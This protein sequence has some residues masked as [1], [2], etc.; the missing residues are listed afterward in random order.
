MDD[1]GPPRAGRVPDEARPGRR[2]RAGLPR[3]SE[4]PAEQRL[5]PLRPL[6]GPARPEQ[7]RQRVRSSVRQDLV[8]GGYPDQELVHVPGSEPGAVNG[9]GDHEEEEEQELNPL[10]LHDCNP[11]WSPARIA[12]V[13]FSVSPPP[14]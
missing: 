2:G 13:R 1:P 10:P 4:A 12:I 5:E 3:R 14:G 9:P 8:Q 7:G 11:P 6:A